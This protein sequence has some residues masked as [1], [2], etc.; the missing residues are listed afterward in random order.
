MA[1]YLDLG[2]DSFL[3]KI[4][5]RSHDLFQAR[6]EQLE[7][8]FVSRTETSDVKKQT[9]KVTRP[10][11]I[12]DKAQLKEVVTVRTILCN[13]VQNDTAELMSSPLVSGEKYLRPN[14][15]YKTRTVLD[16][17]EYFASTFWRPS[18][19]PWCVL[20]YLESHVYIRAKSCRKWIHF[21]SISC[22]EFKIA[23]GDGHRL[24]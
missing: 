11:G 7:V 19:K 12:K 18:K 21:P 8:F 2:K 23:T 5:H 10:K 9:P 3:E 14:L 1:G 20:S 22:S 16:H 15:Y 6:D 17:I 24:V 13:F 4:N